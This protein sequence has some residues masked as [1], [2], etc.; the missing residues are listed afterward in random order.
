MTAI[1]SSTSSSISIFSGSATQTTDSTQLPPFE[2]ASEK[3]SPDAATD[4]SISPEAKEK[5]ER[6][7][8]ERLAAERLVQ[9][10]SPD[11]D[12]EENG[13]LI[14]KIF[15]AGSN[16]ELTIDDLVGPQGQETGDV[17]DSKPYG[18]AVNADE[19]DAQLAKM[20]KELMV[21]SVEHRDPEAA[22]A[23]REAI[24]DG[25][26]R[27][28]KAEDVPGVNLKT[29]VTYT[30]GI[31][32]GGMS[33]QDRTFNPSPEIQAEIDSGHATTMWNKNQGD[34]YITW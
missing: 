11:T 24:A 14:D 9:I 13:S 5:F 16:K 26:V 4:V 18:R 7:E 17:G 31:G 28:R 6:L 1:Q 33:T 29:T 15:A 22:Q 20:T 10:L 12:I 3:V 21:H 32:G 8:S 27:I 23:L 30:K 19:L 25:T 2:E 34:L